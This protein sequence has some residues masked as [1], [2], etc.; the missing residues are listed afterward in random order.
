LLKLLDLRGWAHGF[1]G[2]GD[3]WIANY[4]YGGPIPLLLSAPPHI[5]PEATEKYWK[6]VDERILTKMSQEELEFY[7]WLIDRTKELIAH[8]V[9]VNFSKESK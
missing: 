1:G 8:A 3:Q 4:G 7:S 5:G 2:D 9:E 6:W